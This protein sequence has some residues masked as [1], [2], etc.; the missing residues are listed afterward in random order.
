MI[1]VKLNHMKVKGLKLRS[2]MVYSLRV[3][4]R[5]QRLKNMIDGLWLNIFLL[6]F[7]VQRLSL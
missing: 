5:G 4:G 1:E 2:N 6:S 7:R 3:K